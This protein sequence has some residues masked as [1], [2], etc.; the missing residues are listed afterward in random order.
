MID[1]EIKCIYDHCGVHT[2]LSVGGDYERNDNLAY[3]FA[4]MVCKV[5]EDSDCNPEIIVEEIK[6]HFLEYFK[7]KKK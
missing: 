4:Q 6:E 2:E 5:I 3:D 7:E 1:G